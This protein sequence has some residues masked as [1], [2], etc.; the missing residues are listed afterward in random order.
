MEY[1]V[2]DFNTTF[3][4]VCNLTSN[5]TNQTISWRKSYDKINS[6]YLLTTND[7]EIDNSGL[8]VTFKALYYGDQQYYSCNNETGG[9]IKAYYLYVRGE[10]LF[11][12]SY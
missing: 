1:V 5:N 3:T 11:S 2:G 8:Q 12:N 6:N 4:L 7:I 10:F 9:L